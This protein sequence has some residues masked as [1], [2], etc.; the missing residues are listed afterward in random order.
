MSRTTKH[1]RKHPPLE[2]GIPWMLWGLLIGWLVGAIDEMVEGLSMLRMLAGGVAGVTLGAVAD[3][4]RSQLRKRAATR[5]SEQK[6]RG[7]WD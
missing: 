5:K 4:I 7:K 3:V 6:R 2:A 1:A